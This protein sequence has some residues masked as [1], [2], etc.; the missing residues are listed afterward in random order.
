MILICGFGRHG[1]RIAKEL[2]K[3]GLEYVAIDKDKNAA[4]GY[5]NVLVGDAKNEEILK[6][7]GIKHAKSI[8][9]VVDND[10]DAM[11]IT[12]VARSLNSRVNIVAKADN[13][14]AVDKLEKVGANWVITPYIV[15]GKLLAKYAVSPMAA[16]FLD[17]LIL[18]NEYEIEQIPVKK[19]HD[20]TL[21]EVNLTKYCIFVLGIYRKNEL[22]I[23]PTAN[24]KLKKGD[25]LIIIG[26]KENIEIIKDIV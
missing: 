12:L 11:L 25:I 22:F 19:L 4:E 3:L 9:V 20:K 14:E 26:K 10:A 17:T 6:R 1:K 24:F 15:A 8:I 2:E 13:L 16:S 5:E 21:K 18:G 7:A 23:S